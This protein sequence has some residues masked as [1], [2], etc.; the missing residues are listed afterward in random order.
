LAKE[1]QQDCW[2]QASSEVEHEI[3]RLTPQLAMHVDGPENT[4]P[5]QE[6]G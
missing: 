4:K 2:K 3:A 6:S 1:N 5:L